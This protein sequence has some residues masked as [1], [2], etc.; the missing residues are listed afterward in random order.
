MDVS[1]G[2][3]LFV[4]KCYDCSCFMPRLEVTSGSGLWSIQRPYGVVVGSIHYLD[5]VYLIKNNVINGCWIHAK[6][7]PVVVAKG[8]SKQGWC[9]ITAH[10]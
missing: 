3:V 2:G 5:I 7:R 1:R 9:V 6:I 10:V 4:H 8:Q